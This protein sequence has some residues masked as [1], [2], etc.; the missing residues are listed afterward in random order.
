MLSSR[1]T[2]QGSIILGSDSTSSTVSSAPKATFHLAAQSRPIWL[3]L[4]AP[5]TLPTTLVQKQDLL[6]DPRSIHLK[7]PTGRSSRTLT[8]RRETRTENNCGMYHLNE[9]YGSS[10]RSPGHGRSPH[11]PGGSRPRSWGCIPRKLSLAINFAACL[12]LFHSL[13]STLYHPVASLQSPPQAVINLL[14]TTL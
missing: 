12:V 1:L 7:S 4:Q 8:A 11:S 14:I 6:R 13:V 3:P 5:P 9:K 10:S 2:I